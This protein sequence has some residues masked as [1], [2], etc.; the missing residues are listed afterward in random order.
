MALFFSIAPEGFLEV[1]ET[2]YSAMHDTSNYF[3]YDL[4]KGIRSLK[5]T[6][7]NTPFDTS[8][9]RE[10]TEVELDFIAKNFWPKLTAQD[11]A[12]A[13]TSTD[14][15][16]R[17]DSLGLLLT[18][19]ESLLSQEEK[20]FIT[21]A[22]HI[23]YAQS[24]QSLAAVAIALTEHILLSKRN[25]LAIPPNACSNC[26]GSGQIEFVEANDWVIKARY[27]PSCSDK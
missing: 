12:K 13:K 21:R 16:H 1:K 3:Y 11:K 22:A 2:S 27:C 4:E 17:L 8:Y 9:V 20:E 15:K 7:S 23:A 26:F 18:P 24:K 14:F 19:K 25:E 6:Q 5:G 10:L